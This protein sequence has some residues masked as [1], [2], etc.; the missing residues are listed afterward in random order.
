MGNDGSRKRNSEMHTHATSILI[1][2]YFHI[3][4]VLAYGIWNMISYKLMPLAFHSSVQ[5][6]IQ[7]TIQHNNK[8][9]SFQISLKFQTSFR[10]FLTS[11]QAYQ[12]IIFKEQ[13]TLNFETLFL[14]LKIQIEF[15]IHNES[16]CSHSYHCLCAFCCIDSGIQSYHY[17]ILLFQIMVCQIVINRNVR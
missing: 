16:Y 12:S 6:R 13:I 14:I 3:F 15:K 7:S 4:H 8:I 9:S 2:F 11:I 17:N 10:T 5:F 1:F